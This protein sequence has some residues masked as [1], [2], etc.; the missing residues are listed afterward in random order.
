MML[1]YKIL[2]HVRTVLIHKWYVGYYCFKAGLY[3]QG[4]LH[5]ISKFSYTE[6]S[7]SIKYANGKESPINTCK[8]LK[9]YSSAWF[10][11]RGRNPH[12]YEM[13]IDNFDN[14]GEPVQMP[15]K[16][17]LELICDYLG[18]GKAYMKHG[19]SY[20]NEYKWW[21]NK[22]NH[23]VAMHY[24]TETF[25]DKVLYIISKDNS[26]DILSDKKR[27]KEL[28]IATELEY[29]QQVQAGKEK[30]DVFIRNNVKRHLI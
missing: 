6:L 28:Y 4:F 26:I 13:W 9:G 16:Y 8:K 23:G 12:H 14:G 21:L 15:F 5:D 2:I 29:L 22:K 24:Q 20:A 1:L 18:A 25:I 11:H 3:K 17:V 7:E 27:L 30:P 19:F 10:H